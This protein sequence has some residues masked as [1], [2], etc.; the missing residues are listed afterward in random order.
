MNLSSPIQ[1][2][3]TD[4]KEPVEGQ[5]W[6]NKTRQRIRLFL[7]GKTQEFN[8]RYVNLQ[9]SILVDADVLDQHQPKPPFHYHVCPSG[10]LH[11]CY[12]TSRSIFTWKFF[13]GITLSFPV[14]HAIWTKLWPFYKLTELLGLGVH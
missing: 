4:P 11:R 2:F 13:V 1:V 7:G 5:V 12:R 14:E 10:F 8:S 9:E 3:D 6:F